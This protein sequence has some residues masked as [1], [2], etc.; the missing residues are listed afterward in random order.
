MDL[1]N[2]KQIK[3]LF[4]LFTASF[5]LNSCGI[6]NIYKER[7]VVLQKLKASNIVLAKQNDSLKAILVKKQNQPDI[8]SPTKDEFEAS[9]NNRIKENKD[10]IDRVNEILS[11]KIVSDNKLQ[12]AIILVKDVEELISYNMNTIALLEGGLNN[13]QL[14]FNTKTAFKSGRY[15]IAIEKRGGL[16]KD[17]KPI[18][19]SIIFTANKLSKLTLRARVVI[20]GYSDEQEIEVGSSLYKEL[21]Y[22]KPN[23]KSSEELNLLLS[24]K[25][26]N[27]IASFVDSIVKVRKNEF[28]S[29]NRFK[30][31]LISK[32]NGTS[33][34]VKY[35][36][37]YMKEDSRR[38]IVLMSYYLL[39]D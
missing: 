14:K 2:Q 24:Q 28:I 10:K 15:D 37:D 6:L 38:R 20:S 17:I 5:L 16:Y 33:K 9:L 34:P 7:K 36:T 19:D 11:K 12:E 8:D 25:R 32:G 27:T 31:E 39:N 13:E 23:M 21:T 22:E 29:Y 4:I 1:L 30:L 26:A 35:I 3:L 18:I